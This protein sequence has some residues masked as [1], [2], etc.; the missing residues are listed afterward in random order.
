MTGKRKYTKS[1]QDRTQTRHLEKITVQHVADCK[2]CGK[3]QVLNRRVLHTKH[4]HPWFH[5]RSKCSC[6]RYQHPVSGE[7]IQCDAYT[8][9]R[10]LAFEVKQTKKQAETVED[11][12]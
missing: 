4:T 1:P 8:L 2:D 12:K 9:N 10:G 3:T 11:D 7:W 5:W 6:G